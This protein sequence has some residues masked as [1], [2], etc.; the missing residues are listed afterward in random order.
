MSGEEVVADFSAKLLTD[1]IDQ[2][3]PVKGRVLLN[4]EQLVL[5]TGDEK[6]MIL[7]SHIASTD[8]GSVAD[9]ISQF[10]EEAIAI[11]YD[12]GG[13]QK[14]AVIGGSSDTITK[15]RTRLFKLLVGKQTVIAKHPAKR[16]GRR[17]GAPALKMVL[18]IQDDSIS[19]SKDDK[20]ANIYVESVIGYE[21][22]Q[23]QLLDKPRSTLIVDHAP[24]DTTLTTF[25]SLLSERKLTFLSQFIRQNYS[26][27]VADVKNI[28]VGEV[29]T[30]TL[31]SLYSAGG[32]AAVDMVVTG[33]VDNP[34]ALLEQLEEKRLV[35]RRDDQVHLTSRGEI[36]V[37]DQI[38]AVNE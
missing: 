6:E 30:Q 1:D 33:S 21:H 10:F 27:V 16:G 22:E 37:T 32:N 2:L 26:R 31:V 9:R 25:I 29:E 17:T 28:D 23:R 20:S 34:D 24:G 35:T 3:K 8:P 12:R 7:L 14:R 13:S 5:V 19:L 36:V 18:E 15:F 4:R 11:A 38:E